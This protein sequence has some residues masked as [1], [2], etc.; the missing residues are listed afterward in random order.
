MRTKEPPDLREQ[1]RAAI[2]ASGLSA[3]ALGRLA[4]VHRATLTRFLQGKR[5]IGLD[6][7]AALAVALKLTLKARHTGRPAT[8]P[9]PT[10]DMKAL[11][12]KTP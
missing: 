5:G 6:T 1:L 9:T 10:D 11:G 3:S 12:K 4:G 8:G 2:R 7:A